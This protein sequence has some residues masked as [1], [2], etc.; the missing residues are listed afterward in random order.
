CA[1][2]GNGLVKCWGSNTHGQLGL[3][4]TDHRGDQ[5]G[6]MGAALDAVDLGSGRR[7]KALAVGWLHA[8]VILDND[9][10]KCWG[11]NA[12]GQL[13]IGDTHSRGDGPGQ[14][15][16][17]L[18]EVDLGDGRAARAIAAGGQHTCVLL[19]NDAVKCWGANTF[20][21]LGIG[22]TDHRG[23]EGGELGDALPAVSFGARRP[24]S[25]FAGGLHTCA[26]L[27][28]QSLRCWGDNAASQLGTGNSAT[29]GDDEGESPG[30]VSLGTGRT[31]VSV[32]IGQA[33]RGMGATGIPYA[34]AIL[35]NFTL[36]CW[37]YLPFDLGFA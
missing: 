4:D 26:M 8:C 7:A 27:D 36:K 2:F 6:E 3:G 19:D 5:V 31:A 10:V 13:G 37:S 29:L 25:L 24:I 33:G 11:A 16:D 34:C 23:D 32:G 21:Q 17:A 1:L 14:M 30:I 12:F 28:D 15:G 18:Y 20:G 9:A 22:G 35:D